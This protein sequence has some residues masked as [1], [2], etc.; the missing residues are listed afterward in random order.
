VEIYANRKRCSI[1]EYADA[2][3]AV[4]LRAED[5]QGAVFVHEQR[6]NPG[7]L[8]WRSDGLSPYLKVFFCK[9]Q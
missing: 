2:T 4:K 7:P 8:G 6:F 5:S 1:E 3:D 9:F